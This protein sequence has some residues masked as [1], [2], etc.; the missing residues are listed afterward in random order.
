METRV[1][2]NLCPDTIS[3]LLS[4]RNGT[5]WR[6]FA[7]GLGYEESYAAT[8]NKAARGIPGAMT[9]K[10]ENILRVK[11]GLPPV[12]LMEVAACPDC[13]EAHVGRCYN[14]QVIQ[15][16]VLAPGERVT[17]HPD[18][19]PKRVASPRKPR[20]PYW[21]PCL[22]PEFESVADARRQELGLTWAEFWS[23]VVGAA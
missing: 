8:L 10:A 22:P 21:R 5:P 18:P 13:G 23:Q 1:R 14:K 7:V 19:E 17:A 16:V 6:D 12:H 11:L 2:H 15:V 3:T 4:R 20:R 9:H